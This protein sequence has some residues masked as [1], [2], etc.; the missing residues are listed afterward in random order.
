VLSGDDDGINGDRLVLL[1]VANGHLALAVG[2]E[3]IHDA[4][5]AHI[6]Q[7]LGQLV[8][9]HDGRRHQL[10]RL[11]AGVA[12]HH[13]LIARALLVVGI[14]AMAI[15]PL[16]DVRRLALDGYQ[17]SAGLPVEPHGRVLVPDALDHVAHDGGELDLGGGRDL[18]RHHDKA[19]LVKASQA[20]RQVLSSLMMASSTPSDTWSHSCQGGL[21]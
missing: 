13:A 7:P 1:V 9:Q 21:R 11:V 3:E 2:T 5:L 14:D 16:G 15:H 10:R 4:L 19:V 20:T 18:A 17:H 6:R 12:E 8:R